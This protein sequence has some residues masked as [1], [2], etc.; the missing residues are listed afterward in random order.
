M[1][2]TCTGAQ[3]TIMSKNC[4]EKCEIMRLMDNR[5]AGTARGV[6]VQKISGK[7][8]QQNKTYSPKSLNLTNKNEL[9]HPFSIQQVKFI[10]VK[11]KLKMTFCQ[12]HLRFS[13]IKIWK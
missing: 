9:I 6:G 4:A 1:L 2:I 13:K 8:C 11:Y 3:V 5:F 7:F 10:S 12:L